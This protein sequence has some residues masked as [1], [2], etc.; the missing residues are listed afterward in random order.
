ME[1]IQHNYTAILVAIFPLALGTLLVS[2]QHIYMFAIIKHE[3]FVVCQ[4]KPN[5]LIIMVV[6]LVISHF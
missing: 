6:I 5:K 3:A 4:K 1:H 2:L